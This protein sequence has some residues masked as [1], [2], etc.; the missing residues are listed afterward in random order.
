MTWCVRQHASLRWQH[1]SSLLSSRG[2]SRTCS[3]LRLYHLGSRP[4]P[5]TLPSHHAS[6]LP[7][8][9]SSS[10]LYLSSSLHDSTIRHHVSTR[11][12]S[13]VYVDEEDVVPFYV[14]N[15][16]A[17][18]SKPIGWLRP[19]VA[20]ALNEDHETEFRRH[21]RSPW[22]LEHTSDG[23]LLSAAFASWINTEGQQQRTLHMER[24]VMKWRQARLFADILR[25]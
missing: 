19:L 25:G 1:S 8:V 10:N 20:N 24:L 6:L 14:S 4:A 16:T 21:Q 15:P 23:V 22:H 13:N 11:K 9:C 17:M 18:L 7:L 12:E 2:E 3:N 5:L